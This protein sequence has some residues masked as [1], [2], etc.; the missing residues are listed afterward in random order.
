MEHDIHR[1]I[2]SE[3]HVPWVDQSLYSPKLKVII[4]FIIRHAIK[5]E[6]TPNSADFVPQTPLSAQRLPLLI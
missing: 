3:Y 2:R 5:F 4:C 6:L 1:G